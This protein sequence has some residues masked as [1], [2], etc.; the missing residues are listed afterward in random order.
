MK[1]TEARKISQYCEVRMEICKNLVDNELVPY[2]A[3]HDKTDQKFNRELN[4]YSIAAKGIP[5]SLIASLRG[6]FM[7]FTIFKKGG[8]IKKYLENG[9]FSN[10]SREEISYLKG[11]L[12]K[13]MRYAFCH[14]LEKK[15]S[16]FYLLHDSMLD[17]EFL[18]YSPAMTRTMRDLDQV[19][20]FWLLLIN[21]NGKCFETYGPVLYFM[22]LSTDDVIFFAISKMAGKNLG[23][24]IGKEFSKDLNNDPVPYLMLAKAMTF[25]QT[26][27]RGQPVLLFTSAQEL[28]FLIDPEL[29]EFN[30]EIEYNQG[31][32]KLG[33][34]NLDQWPHFS[35]AYFNED[36]LSLEI[37]SMTENGFLS[38][39]DALHKCGIIVDDEPDFVL[40]PY[41]S[42][43]IQEILKKDGNPDEYG[44]LFNEEDDLLPGG[45]DSDEQMESM[46]NFLFLL[47]EDLNQGKEPNLKELSKKSNLPME[48]AQQLMEIAKNQIER[49]KW[50]RN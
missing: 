17:K 8:L 15:A 40:Q 47:L 7:G 23:K 35:R 34:I 12:K 41:L 50:F 16:D 2:S 4:N 49:T 20:D 39:I 30:F 43:L 9:V 38:L 21:D 28:E 25:N 26:V 44:I 6:Q 31:V 11:F 32:Y 48:V 18:I 29:L 42:G 27:V 45:E 22:S 46:N 1:L 24:N 3:K 10:K 14:L 13:P 33:L 37:H 19:I 5:E 36:T